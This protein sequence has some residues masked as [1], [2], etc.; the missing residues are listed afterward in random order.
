MISFEIQGIPVPQKQTRFIRVTGRA[1][2]PSHDDVVAFQRKA[3]PYAPCDPWRIPIRM[4]L[5]FYLP[6]PKSF[7]QRKRT[8]FQEGQLFPITKPDVD[9]LAYL[10]TNAMKKIFYW[11]DAQL[12]DL[13]L[14]KRYGLEP[15]TVVHIQP[16]EPGEKE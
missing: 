9:N 3:L 2:N 11:D 15:R 8:Q 10:V 4:S 16:H 7:S 5:W 1:Y 6:I 14:F 13:Q 12:V